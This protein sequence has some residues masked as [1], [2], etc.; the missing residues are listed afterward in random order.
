M[1]FQLSTE[2]RSVENRVH[3]DVSVGD[4]QREAEVA[5]LVTPGATE[6]WRAAQGPSRG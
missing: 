2:P 3:L 5:R 6:L 1:L 4:D